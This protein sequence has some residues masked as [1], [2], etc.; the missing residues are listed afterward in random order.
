MV[1]VMHSYK[2]CREDR[3]E[4]NGKIH[5]EGSFFFFRDG[6]HDIFISLRR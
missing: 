5:K 3:H 1:S 2:T 4:R 6:E